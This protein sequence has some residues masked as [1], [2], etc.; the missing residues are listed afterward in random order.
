MNRC[1]V[2]APSPGTAICQ[3][4]YIPFPETLRY[5]QAPCRKPCLSL[6]ASR[7]M[8]RCCGLCVDR[9]RV[10]RASVTALR[11]ASREVI[12]LLL[13]QPTQGCFVFLGFFLLAIGDYTCSRRCP[14]PLA[15]HCLYGLHSA[16]SLL[17]SLGHFAHLAIACDH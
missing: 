6:H 11:K 3:G 14:N 1:S 7:C 16:K 13:Q 12:S 8:L 5:C 4:K 15:R 10:S 9:A 2:P 17:L